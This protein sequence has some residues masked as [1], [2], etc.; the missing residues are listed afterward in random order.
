M[1]TLAET[2]EFNM[3]FLDAVSGDE[4]SFRKMS[5]DMTDYLRIYLREEGIAR[6]MLTPKPTT[7]QELDRAVDTE[8]PFKVEFKEPFSP[9]AVTVPFGTHPSETSLFHARYPVYF[10]RLLSPRVKKDTALLMNT[11]HDVRQIA[12]D[13]MVKDMMAEEDS[14]FFG[15]I[16]TILGTIDTTSAYVPGSTMYRTVSGFNRAA[17]TDGKTTMQKTVYHVPPTRAVCNNVTWTMIE[18]FT[19]DE[20]GGDMSEKLFLEGNGLGE[21]QGL[22]WKVTI[23][24]FL[25]PDYRVYYFG[26]ENML[27]RFRTLEDV[28]LWAEKKN[29]MLDFF[30]YAMYG[31][32]IAHAGSVAA[33]Q[34]G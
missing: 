22:K 33:V 19:R 2:N 25:V 16:H 34:Y 17:L 21:F 12:T 30:L 27:G 28:T 31:M 9:P 8:L 23:K 11:P 10:S 20:F 15:T 1:P 13:N 3:S 32:T 6:S 29:F 7:W 14:K 18:G 4:Y 24:R 5:A 26:P